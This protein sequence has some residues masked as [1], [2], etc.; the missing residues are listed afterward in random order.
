ML[1]RRVKSD[2]KQRRQTQGLKNDFERLNT[3]I[4][5]LII[6]GVLIVVHAGVW[7]CHLVTNEENTIVARI[8]LDRVAYRR[9][10]PGHDGRLLSHGGSYGLKTK[11]LVDSRYAVLTVRGVVIHV[12]L[13]RMTLA[14]DAFVRDDVFRFGKIGRPRV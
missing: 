6:D 8:R 13:V 2:V 10:R 1:R 5:I 4:E 7:T 12:A 9:A 11:G 3:A 14:P